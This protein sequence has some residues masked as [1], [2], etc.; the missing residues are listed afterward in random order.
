MKKSGL[1]LLLLLF[2]AALPSY[3]KKEKA[4]PKPVVVTF[5][6]DNCDDCDALDVHRAAAET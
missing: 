1:I 5:L 2:V 6:K 3:A 4:V